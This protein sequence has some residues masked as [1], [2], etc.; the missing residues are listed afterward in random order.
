MIRARPHPVTRRF[1]VVDNESG[2]PLEHPINRFLDSLATRGL[3]PATV[4]AYAFDL[5]TL[6]RWLNAGG[7]SQQVDQLTEALLL[8]FVVYQQANNAKPRT[9]N[10]RLVTTRSYYEF[11]TGH[12]MPRGIGVT[13][14]G[15]HHRGRGRERSLGLHTRQRSRRLR[16]CV[17][18][19]R[20]LIE[21]LTAEQ[22][23]AFLRTVRRYRDLAIV[24][25]LLLCG[26]R[27]REVLNMEIDDIRVDERQIRVHGKGNKE[28]VVF[29]P[30]P[31]THALLGY[32]KFE[33]PA[34]CLT[35][36][37]FVALQGPRRGCPMTPAGLRSLFRQRRRQQNIARANPHR[38]RHTFGVDMI[39][40]GVELPALQKLMG[41][42]DIT[43]TMG[44]VN[45]SLSDIA[46]DYHRALERMRG[47]YET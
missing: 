35:R 4:R 17:K 42:A 1:C 36:R 7:A 3:S 43:T 6:H 24:Y 31:L 34:R 23:R 15:A 32:L 28:R 46:D 29:L 22:V 9:I 44:Y 38:F 14:H 12:E 26:L 47:K 39:R 21:P 19:P 13:T 18:V 27:S 10:R 30:N 40:E 11:V 5:V 2:E 41:H 25:L 16:L 45:L 20:T 8:D 37:I 33:R